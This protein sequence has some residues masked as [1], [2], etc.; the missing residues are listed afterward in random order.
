MLI[1]DIPPLAVGDFVV[2]DNWSQSKS[3]YCKDSGA[4]LRLTLNSVFDTP[5][6]LNLP[7]YP[8]STYLIWPWLTTPVFLVVA[9]PLAPNTL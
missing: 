6:M 3:E 5:T 7:V 4:N 9:T 2:Y 8:L 1:E